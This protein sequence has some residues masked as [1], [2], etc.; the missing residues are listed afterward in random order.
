MFLEVNRALT[1]FLN[2]ATDGVNAQLKILLAKKEA[3]KEVKE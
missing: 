1:D 3:K 2:D